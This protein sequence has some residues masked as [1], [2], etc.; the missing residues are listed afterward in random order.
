MINFAAKKIT[1]KS[2][3][4]NCVQRMEESQ[5]YINVMDRKDEFHNKITCDW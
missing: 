4:D 5:A 1:K 2:S 3:I